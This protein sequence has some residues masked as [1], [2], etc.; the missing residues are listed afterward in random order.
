MG[1]AAPMAYSGAPMLPNGPQGFV[2][3]PSVYPPTVRSPPGNAVLPAPWPQQVAFNMGA[4]GGMI[5]APAM[6]P[7]GTASVPPMAGMGVPGGAPVMVGRQ[8]FSLVVHVP[9][10]QI[11]LEL[12]SAEAPSRAKRAHTIIDDASVPVFLPK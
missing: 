4:G 9:G 1:G 2:P 11:N 3:S 7:P 5:G 10:T 12:V 8:F 6:M